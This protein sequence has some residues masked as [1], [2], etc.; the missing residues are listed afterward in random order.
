MT[1][2]KCKEGLKANEA[3]HSADEAWNSQI[4]ELAI[5]GQSSE[6]LFETSRAPR[7]RPR[8]FLGL[9]AAHAGPVMRV[10]DI[11]VALIFLYSSAAPSQLR[12]SGER[13]VPLP[14][15]AEEVGH[16]LEPVVA[17]EVVALAGTV[18]DDHPGLCEV[19]VSESST[20]LTEKNPR[21]R[22]RPPRQ[23]WPRPP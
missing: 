12:L 9:L 19:R 22:K 23:S 11:L 10:N 14:S 18:L 13:T 20:G 6:Y 8:S 3:R 17:E 5:D 1:S 2:S 4:S 7:T 21:N 15:V 16:Y